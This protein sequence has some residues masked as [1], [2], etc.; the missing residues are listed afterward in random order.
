MPRRRIHELPLTAAERQA[1]HRAKL[2][3]PTGP[4]SGRPE[5]QA[6]RPPTHGTGA[7]PAATAPALAA[8]VATL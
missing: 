8:A 5:G 6:T 7:A 2:R 4:A 3:Q 1:R